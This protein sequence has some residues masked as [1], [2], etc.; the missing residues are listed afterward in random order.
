MVEGIAHEVALKTYLQVIMG[1]NPQAV[2]DEMNTR[3]GKTSKQ[4]YNDV[5]SSLN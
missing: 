5:W 4:N 3:L 1:F 2:I